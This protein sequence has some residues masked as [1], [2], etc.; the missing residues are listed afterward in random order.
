MKRMIAVLFCITMIAAF[1]AAQ[2]PAPHKAPAHMTV[3]GKVTE[4]TATALKIERSV[5]G[6]AEAMEF[7]LDKPLTGFAV[8]DEVVVKYHVKDG[9]SV[10]IE[11]Q[12]APAKK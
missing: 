10:A 3:T 4:L 12:K 9:K 7:T 6:K 2:A 11:V 8:G 1:A 5:K